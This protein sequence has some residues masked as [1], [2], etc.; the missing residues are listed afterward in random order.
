MPSAILYRCSSLPKTVAVVLIFFWF[1]PWIGVPVKPK[2]SAFGNVCLMVCII[3]PKVERWHSSTIKTNRF[4]L[5]SAMSLGFS[6]FCA[7]SLILLIFWMEVTM[8]VSDGEVL[9]SL[10]TRTSV[11]S[12]ACTSSF[13]SAKLRYS[14]RLWVPNSILSIRKITLSASLEDAISWA[15][16]KEVMVLP[17]PVVCQ[18]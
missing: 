8:S 15:D 9:F 6:L 1:S 3:S 10:S 5:I 4:A 12:V 7:S 18:M 2:N 11:F 14:F 17:E 13:S 16:L